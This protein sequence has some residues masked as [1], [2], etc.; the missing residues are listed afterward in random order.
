MCT[1]T[2]EGAFY[3]LVYETAPKSEAYR[4]L[5][6]FLKNNITSIE[7][8]EKANIKDM[9]NFKGIGPKRQQIIRAMV[10]KLLDR[11]AKTWVSFRC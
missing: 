10:G 9:L 1:I 7:Q 5:I 2:P 6:I 8:F 3:D 4:M 11:R